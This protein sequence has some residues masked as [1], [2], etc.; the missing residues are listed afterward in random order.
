M[1]DCKNPRGYSWRFED[2]GNN[3]HGN[4]VARVAAPY[5][6]SLTEILEGEDELDTM[7]IPYGAEPSCGSGCLP[8]DYA[9]DRDQL[10]LSMSRTVGGIISASTELHPTLESICHVTEPASLEL[11]SDHCHRSRTSSKPD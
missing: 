8:V 1:D 4:E 3:K 11:R 2:K 7:A 5:G 6:H 9:D 10:V